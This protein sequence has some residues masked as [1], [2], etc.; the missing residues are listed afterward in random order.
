MQARL[1]ATAPTGSSSLDSVV[2]FA[3]NDG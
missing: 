2:Q 3:D 1:V